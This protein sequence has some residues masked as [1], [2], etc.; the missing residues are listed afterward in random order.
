MRDRLIELIQEADKKSFEYIREND[1]MDYIPT[2]DELCGVQAD[3]LLAHG[4]VVPP[5][6]VGDTV[7]YLA[8]NLHTKLTKIKTGTVV[9]IAI[10]EDGIDLFA[11]N[12]KAKL[13]YGKRSFLTKEEVEQALVNYGSSKIEKGGAE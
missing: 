4:V 9:R 6:K 3:Y 1:N 11:D 5:C 8:S 10:T 7:Y 12:W 2:I 13:P